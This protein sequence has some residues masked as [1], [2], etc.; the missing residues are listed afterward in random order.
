MTPAK[1]LGVAPNA[2]QLF[3]LKA[4]HCDAK[5]LLPLIFA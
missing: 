3:P 4:A 1:M 2:V 5:A